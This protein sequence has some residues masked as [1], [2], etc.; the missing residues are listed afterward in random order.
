MNREVLEKA[1]VSSI[2]KAR[3]DFKWISEFPN[4]SDYKQNNEGRILQAYGDTNFYGEKV[5]KEGFELATFRL[6]KEGEEYNKDE[7]FLGTINVPLEFLAC[8]GYSLGRFVPGLDVFFE[9]FSNERLGA[10]F[11]LHKTTRS[12]SS[13]FSSEELRKI[14]ELSAK[15]K[16]GS[17]II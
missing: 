6:R 12:L 16:S 17:L 2:E 4:F 7:L 10:Y 5:I 14:E 15:R 8:Q 1:I 13:L 11:G 3:I 9:Y